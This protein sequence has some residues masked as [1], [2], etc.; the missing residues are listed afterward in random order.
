MAHVA[1]RPGAPFA[2]FKPYFHF[3]LTVF[4]L[5]PPFFALGACYG[6]FED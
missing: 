4:F 3:S 6:G 2:A 5:L 1:L